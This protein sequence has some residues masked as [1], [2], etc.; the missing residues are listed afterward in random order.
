MKNE[1]AFIRKCPQEKNGMLLD[2]RFQFLFASLRLPI[3]LLLMSMLL[4]IT[5]SLAF[6]NNPQHH[7]H[8]CPQSH[9]SQSCGLSNST[10]IVW[11]VSSISTSGILYQVEPRSFTEKDCMIYLRNNLMSF[12]V[13]NAQSLGF[14]KNFDHDQPLPDGLS[15]GLVGPTISLALDAKRYPWT[16][17]VPKEIYYEYVLNFANVN[18]GRT[19]WRPLLHEALWPLIEPLSSQSPSPNVEQIVNVVNANIWDLFGKSISFQSGK[20]P[21]IYDPMSIIAFGYAS[22]TGLSIL[23]INAL[24]AV[25]IPARLAGT[26]AWNGKKES[27]NHSWVEFFG[28]DGQWHIMESRPAAGDVVNDLLDPCQWWFWRPEKV[29]GTTFH[30]ARLER[31]DAKSVPFPMAWDD[32]NHGVPGE[33]RSRFMGEL[34]SKC[35]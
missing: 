18:E 29:K 16:K 23:L 30:A 5:N 28:S 14:P 26:S 27:G 24:R 34:C 10:H 17:H 8:P 13:P 2:R 12:D 32:D 3:F 6:Q 1:R 22:C 33:D 11:P 35:I 31:S 9:S 19:N 20:T 15:E 21:L 4:N 7:V 25:G